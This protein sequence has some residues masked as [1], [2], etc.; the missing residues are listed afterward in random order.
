MQPNDALAA[1]WRQAGMPAASLSHVRL[2]GAEPVLPS[3]F[4][5]GTAAQTSIAASAAAAAELWRVRTGRAQQVRV[6]MRDAAIEFRSERYL[7]VNGAPLGEHTDKIH[8]LYRCGDGRWVRIHANLPHHRDGVLALLGCA[9]D[10]AAVT[11]ALEGWKAEDLETAASERGL[12]VTAMRTFAEW[13]RHP[14]G[15]AAARLPALSIEQIGEAPPLALGQG[16][17]PLSGL[18]VLD[19]TRI[20]AGPVCGRTLAAHGA[21]VLLVTAAHL[22]SVEVLVIDSGR[23]KLTTQ[24]DLREQ[25]GRAALAGLV[26]DAHVFVQGYRPGGL[27]GRGFSPEQVATLRPGIVYVTLSAY[28]HLGPWAGRRG[29]DSLVQT[30]SGFNAAEAEAAGSAKPLAMPCQTLD[31]GSGYLMAFGALA[32]LHRRAT[33]GGS[34][35]VRVSLA[36]TGTWLRTLGRVANGLACPDPKFA[37][38]QD[39]LEECES[40][41]GKLTGVREAAELSETPPRWVLPSVPLG[42]HPPRWPA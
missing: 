41:F 28:G 16:Q 12:V 22:P 17:R 27:G 20:I 7:R 2:T 19:L 6:A 31:H 8:A 11:K 21:D 39:R 42:T 4:A 15:Q 40:G 32:A 34:W 38:V 9:H 26:Q 30:A 10:K 14:Q 1:L 25:A 13:D 24:I 37:D 3:S 36:G 5:V 33:I 18:R 29:F 23:G 35:H